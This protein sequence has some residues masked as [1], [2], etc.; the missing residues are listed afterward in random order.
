MPTVYCPSCGSKQTYSGVKPKK[1]SACDDLLEPKPV[2]RHEKAKRVR[3]VEVED[4]DPPEVIEAEEE[5]HLD[6]RSLKIE[7]FGDGIL[8]VKK[9]RESE[10]FGGRP[11]SLEVPQSDGK[12]SSIRDE[13]LAKMMGKPTKP[14]DLAPPPEKH[15]RPTVRRMPSRLPPPPAE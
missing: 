14:A 5:F 6:P 1:C 3:Y 9:L 7:R 12:M 4:D 15:A 8:T 11:A 2:V 13:V 10:G